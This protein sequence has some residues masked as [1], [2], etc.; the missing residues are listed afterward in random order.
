MLN[1]AEKKLQEKF[2]ASEALQVK[3]RL[4]ALGRRAALE[5]CTGR[6]SQI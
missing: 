6:L 2:Y 3:E 1:S 5:D 4:S